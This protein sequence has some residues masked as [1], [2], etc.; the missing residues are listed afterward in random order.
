[1][2]Q[3]RLNEVF[4]SSTVVCGID[5]SGVDSIIRGAHGYRVNSD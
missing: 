5:S 4:R 1:M 3:V 2:L